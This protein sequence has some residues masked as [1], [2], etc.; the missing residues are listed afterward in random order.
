ML[1]F[2]KG[3]NLKITTAEGAAGEAVQFMLM[4]TMMITWC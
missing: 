1:N 4:A 2:S 3:N